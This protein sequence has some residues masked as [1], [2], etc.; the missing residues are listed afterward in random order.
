MK[1]GLKAGLGLGRQVS[2]YRNPAMITKH[3]S[4]QCEQWLQAMGSSEG[5]F[6]S[7]E[8]NSFQGSQ[9]R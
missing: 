8:A 9:Q 7:R 6:L 1:A 4:L 5:S 3:S 2:A